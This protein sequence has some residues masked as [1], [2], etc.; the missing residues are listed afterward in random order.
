MEGKVLGYRVVK[1]FMNQKIQ[2]FIK[3]IDYFYLFSI[4]DGV[5]L[6]KDFRFY[7]IKIIQITWNCL[8]Q[9]RY[10][11]VQSELVDSLIYVPL[12]ERCVG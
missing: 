8:Q 12:G 6:K 4:W 11:P 5:L 9:P 7:Y 10:T 1:E 2:Q 3:E